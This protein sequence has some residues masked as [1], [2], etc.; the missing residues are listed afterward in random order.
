MPSTGTAA[1][2]CA[3]L[4][5]TLTGVPSPASAAGE[6]LSR[7]TSVGVHNAYETAAFPHFAD[8]P[9]SWNRTCG[10]TRSRRRA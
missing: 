9:D 4:P 2:T 10:P 6:A 7:T 1:L 3:A 8:A 5:L